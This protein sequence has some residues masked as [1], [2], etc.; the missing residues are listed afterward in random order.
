MPTSKWYRLSSSLLE[1]SLESSAASSPDKK[2]WG[3][4]LEGDV[5]TLTLF[6][7]K[8]EPVG[9]V[10]IHRK[11]VDGVEM[12]FPGACMAE[13]HEDSAEIDLRKLDS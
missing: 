8:E 7:E 6:N 5:L 3:I 10:E 2:R 12:A 4:R 11:A 13:M 1:L 9:S